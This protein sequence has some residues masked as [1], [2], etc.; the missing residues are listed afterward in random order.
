MK[1]KGRG[2]G[3]TNLSARAGLTYEDCSVY[4]REVALVLNITVSMRKPLL[5]VDTSS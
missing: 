4:I 1:D 2:E 3:Y 5:Q